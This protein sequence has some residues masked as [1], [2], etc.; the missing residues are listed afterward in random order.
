MSLNLKQLLFQFFDLSISYESETCTVEFLVE[1][2]MYNPRSKLHGG[3]IAFVM[4][5]SMGH[6][7][8][9]VIGT[10]VTMEIKIQ[11]LKAVSSGNISCIARFLKK[12]RSTA[13][14]ESRMTDE[15]GD[16]IAMATGTFKKV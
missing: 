14:L 15:A 8:K 3:V 9:K 11:Y 4:D 1:D 6:L 16:L 12:G 10:S 5:V 2:F 13:F 7:C